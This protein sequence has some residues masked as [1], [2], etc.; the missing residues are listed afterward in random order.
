[1]G[2]RINTL[3]V[4]AVAA[5]GAL[6][7]QQVVAPSSEQAGSTRGQDI[8]DYNITNSFELGYRFDT[9][10]G[11]DG[12]YR[13][14]INYAS[15]L[16]LLGSTLTVDS[17][18]GHGRYFD[19][20]LLTTLGLG[21]DPYESVTLRIRKNRLYRYDL[22]WRENQFFDPGVAISGGQH[23]MN[24]TRLLQDHDLT[25][26]PDNRIVQFELGYSRKTLTGPALTSAQ[27]FDTSGDAFTAFS[28]I[29]EQFND[30]RAGATLHL[31]GFT[32]IVRR[33]WEYFKQGTVDSQTTPEGPGIAGDPSVLQSF[34]R[35]Q[36]F[37]GSNGAWFGTLFKARKHWAVNARANMPTAK[38]ILR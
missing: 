26:L 25:L 6:R 2:R 12:L 32:F 15:G 24:T 9:V 37:H 22:I 23:L 20:I 14:D 38:A 29:R 8:G 36:P 1:M 17:N 18:D 31:A 10:Y 19:E 21:N 28:D 35:T 33:T 11:N 27:E 16:R 4:M 13:S 3:I 30:Y 34:Q 5:A 7:A